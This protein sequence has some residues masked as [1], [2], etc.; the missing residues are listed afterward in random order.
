MVGLWQ[1]KS[2]PDP[3]SGPGH[4]GPRPAPAAVPIRLPHAAHGRPLDL[5]LQP[6]GPMGSFAEAGGLAAHR[7]RTDFRRVIP[8]PDGHRPERPEAALVTDAADY[9]HAGAR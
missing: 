3:E 1:R 2:G 8:M 7:G 5:P 4:C 9:T 6:A